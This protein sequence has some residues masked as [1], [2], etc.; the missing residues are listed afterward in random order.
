MVKTITLT[1]II[2]IARQ[3]KEK[4]IKKIISIEKKIIAGELVVLG[5]LLAAANPA[6][7]ASLV[8]GA[9]KALVPKT[10]K[11]AAT[12][13][14]TV[15]TAIG[16]L[17]AS[18]KARSTVKT[19][20]DPREAV[21][22]GKKIGEII[23]EPGKASDILGIRE[24]AT[25]KEKIVSGL[26]TGGKIGAVVAGGLAV[27]AALKKGKQILDER[28]AAKALDPGLASLGFTEPKRVG[29]GGVPIPEAET[30]Q[31][32]P[33]GAPQSTQGA[34]PLYNIIQIAVR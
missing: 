30:P 22:R 13:L 14:I 11:G 27:G 12:A 9:G 19:I 31:F 4:K 29:L 32:T 1:P 8:R 26:K 15:P 10:I 33:L 17:S 20:L 28:K 3:E 18:K 34:Q 24:G 6:A 25:L 21:K 23:E 5:G 7:A 2:D 16:V